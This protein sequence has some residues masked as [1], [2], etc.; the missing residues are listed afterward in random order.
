[1]TSHGLGL[2]FLTPLFVALNGPKGQEDAFVIGRDQLSQA[3][4]KGFHQ[5]GQWLSIDNPQVEIWRRVKVLGRLRLAGLLRHDDGWSVV[6]PLVAFGIRGSVQRLTAPV[7][8]RA[9]GT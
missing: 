5:Q 3:L 1:M 2:A 7:L 6:N 8:R 4:P 9:P